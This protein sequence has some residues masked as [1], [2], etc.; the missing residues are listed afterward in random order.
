MTADRP[1]G[2]ATAAELRRQILHLG[3]RLDG[4]DHTLIEES[5]KPSDPSDIRWDCLCGYGNSPEKVTRHWEANLIEYEAAIPSESA[6]ERAR[7]LAALPEALR[8]V[9]DNIGIA[10]IDRIYISREAEATTVAAALAA[11]I[12]KALGEK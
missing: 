5:S 9:I 6:A 7:I 3:G 12:E 4:F 10:G 2:P 1:T 11:A 8:L